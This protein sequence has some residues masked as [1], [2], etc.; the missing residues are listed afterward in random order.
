MFW[1]FWQLLGVLAGLAA[2]G[3]GCLAICVVFR[4]L[5]ELWEMIGGVA[6][7]GGLVAAWGAAAYLLS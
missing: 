4:T 3:L 1:L 5:G 2:I 7:L 6:V